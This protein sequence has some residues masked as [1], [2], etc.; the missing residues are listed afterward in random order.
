MAPTAV[1]DADDL[2]DHRDTDAHNVDDHRDADA[3][4]DIGRT[5][6]D[7]GSSHVHISR[8]DYVDL[9]DADTDS[10]DVDDVTSTGVERR[11]WW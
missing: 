5:D 8:S 3:H 1:A 11:V 7:V 6:H 2:H 10:D 4:D 9:D